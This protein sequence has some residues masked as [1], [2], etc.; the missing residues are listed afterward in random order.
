M[1]AGEIGSVALVYWCRRASVNKSMRKSRV[2]T[3]AVLE[4]VHRAL[5]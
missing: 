4:G 3:V 5:T 1:M 2:V